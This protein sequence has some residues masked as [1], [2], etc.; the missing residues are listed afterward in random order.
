MRVKSQYVFIIAVAILLAVFFIVASLFNNGSA[1]D[2]A[3]A[4]AGQWGRPRFRSASPQRQCA[5]SR[6]SCVDAPKP[7]AV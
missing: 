2:E 7:P 6:W 3:K 1:R 4:K 5:K